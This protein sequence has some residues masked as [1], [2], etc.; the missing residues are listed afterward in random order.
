MKKD[1]IRVEWSQQKWVGFF[2][3]NILPMTHYKT[4]WIIVCR[5][6]KNILMIFFDSKLFEAPLNC[7]VTSIYELPIRLLSLK[8]LFSNQWQFIVWCDRIKWNYSQVPSFHL[9]W[10]FLDC[11]VSWPLQTW[12]SSHKKMLEH[13][14]CFSCRYF[15]NVGNVLV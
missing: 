5:L 9:L 10:C 11:C 13:P 4:F 15:F 12:S 8:K 1:L 6:N 2:S 7:Q 3:F 14:S